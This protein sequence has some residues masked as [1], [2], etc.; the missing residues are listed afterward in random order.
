MRWLALQCVQHPEKLAGWVRD[1]G[2]NVAVEA[3]C[4]QRGRAY[5]TWV[6]E[7]EAGAAAPPVLPGE[8][9]WRGGAP[10]P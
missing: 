3:V 2:W 7:I 10:P 8:G 9:P 6:L 1:A 4:E 5:P